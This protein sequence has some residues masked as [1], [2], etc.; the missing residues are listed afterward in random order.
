VTVAAVRFWTV[1]QYVANSALERWT[2]VVNVICATV[3]MLVGIT[4]QT[5]CQVAGQLNVKYR[6]V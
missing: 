3:L 4:V 5:M 2:E 6:C 1:S